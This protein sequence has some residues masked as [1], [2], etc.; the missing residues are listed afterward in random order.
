MTEEKIIQQA[1]KDLIRRYFETIDTE[2]K[3]ANADMLDEFLA[4]DFIEHNPFPGLPP[5]RDGWKQAFIMFAKGAPGYHVIDDLIAEDDKVVGHITAYGKH[6]GVLF[7]IP[8]TNKDFSMAGIAIWRIKNGKIT[9]HWN[10][11]DQLGVMMQ[12]GV[13]PPPPH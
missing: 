9:E 10:Q 11:T 4:E 13:L 1:N 8:A 5:N 3:N 7:G 12:L 6:T 2:G